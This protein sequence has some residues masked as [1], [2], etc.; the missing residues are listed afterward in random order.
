M[1]YDEATGEYRPRWGYKKEDDLTDWLI[2]VPD[3]GGL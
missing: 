2:P 1:V 3:N